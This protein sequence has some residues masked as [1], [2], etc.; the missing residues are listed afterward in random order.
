MEEEK[1]HG[2]EYLKVGTVSVPNN[3]DGCLY[4]CPVELWQLWEHKYLLV[5]KEH[6]ISQNFLDM[7]LKVD[8]EA[9]PLT[10]FYINGA[11]EML[12]CYDVG[13]KDK[14]IRFRGKIEFSQNGAYINWICAPGS[15]EHCFDMFEARV[16]RE[17]QIRKTRFVISLTPSESKETLLRRINFYVRK[18]PNLRFVDIGFE[19]EL[20][21]LW[22]HCKIK[23][24]FY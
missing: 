24:E 18:I 5:K 14:E 6:A 7:I 10:G 12:I 16:A 8:T 23:F 3:N 17:R 19:K 1:E 22:F 15:G 11:E 20:G 2:F 21:G 4:A 13:I 9:N